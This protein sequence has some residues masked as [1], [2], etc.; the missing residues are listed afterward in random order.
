M[1]GATSARSLYVSGRPFPPVIAD[2][3]PVLRQQLL[4]RH[5][6][7]VCQGADLRCVLGPSLTRGFSKCLH[8]HH[9]I[10]VTWQTQV[11]VNPDVVRYE[12][13]RGAL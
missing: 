13:D 5:L 3:M 8:K 6:C 4:K 2:H 10:H 1:R 12:H 9:A 11:V 7:F